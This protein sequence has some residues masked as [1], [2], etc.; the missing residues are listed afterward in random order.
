MSYDLT[1]HRRRFAAWAAARGA[2]RGFT[3]V[4]SLRDAL[5]NCGIR[6]FALTAFNAGSTRLV[7]ARGA[8]TGVG[9]SS[10]TFS[11]PELRKRRS[12]EPPSW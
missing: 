2:Q 9:R 4:D 12:A 5:E 1:E 11:A 6:E 7:S 3:T 10:L 8:E